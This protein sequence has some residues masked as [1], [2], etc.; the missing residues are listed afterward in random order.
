MPSPALR[1]RTE[2][3]PSALS[4]PALRSRLGLRSPV[5]A[6]VGACILLAILSA[7]VLPTVPSYDPWSWIVWGRSVLDPHLS[8]LTGGGPSWKPFPVMFTTIYGRFGGAAPTLWVITARAG[9]LLALVAAYRLGAKLVEGLGSAEVAKPIAGVVAV[10]GILLTQDFFYYWYRGATEPIL[11][12]AALWSIDRLIA[13][14]RIQ[15]FVL[16]VVLSQ[17]RPEAWPFLGLYGLWLWRREPKYRWLVAVG[18]VSIPLFWFVPTKIGSG[19][20]FLAASHAS[21]YNGHLGSSPVIEALRRAYNL[22]VPPVVF[23]AVV[24]VVLTWFRERDR[25]TLAL[26]GGAVAWIAVV[27]AMVIDG[28]PGLERFFLPATAILCVLAGAG[29]ARVAVL[30]VGWLGRVSRRVV[31]ASERL[32]AA[33][34][35]AIAL[36]AISVPLASSRI[37][38]ARTVEPTANQAVS[39]LNQLSDAVK[40]VGGKSKV[41]PCKTSAVAINHSAQTA[42]AW[43]LDTDMTRVGTSLRAPGVVFVGPHNSVDGAAAPVSTDLNHSQLLATVGVW[44]VY[45][46]TDTNPTRHVPSDCAGT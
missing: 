17:M 32:A 44:K 10:I 21:S 35:V 24:A 26:A 19:Q 29:F 8:F 5:V 42:L 20:W 23:G 1:R 39:I 2:L 34:A 25:L 27:V 37:D 33:I 46:Y 4:A 22:Q 11:I 3:H 18:F 13:G 6:A 7:I 9:G 41:L 14:K 45:R 38:G 40:A 12:A 36:L 15:A 43:K 30:A 31:S 28:Y 16:L